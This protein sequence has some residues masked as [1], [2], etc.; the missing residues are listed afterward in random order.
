MAAGSFGLALSG[1]VVPGPLLAVVVTQVARRGLWAAW[2]VVAAHSLCEFWVVLGLRSGVLRA[3]TTGAA[4]TAISGAGAV[5]LLVLGTLTARVALREMGK[6]VQAASAG[7][8][9]WAPL[10]GGLAATALNPYWLIWWATVAP[11]YMVRLQ[12]ASAAATAVFYV[13]HIAGDF[14]WYIPLAAGLRSG[15]K[16]LSGPVYQGA[17]LL[18]AGF[19]LALGLW[20]GVG[21]LGAR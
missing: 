10:T 13:S 3:L 8:G 14:A 2:L 7:T 16:R 21:A 5:A 20:F 17:L 1:A 12:V 4:V 9:I 19:L 6:E 18:S 15:Q 11:A